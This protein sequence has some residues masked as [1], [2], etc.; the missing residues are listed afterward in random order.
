MGEWKTGTIGDLFSLT[1]GYAFKSADF[2]ESGVPVIKIKNVKAGQFSEHEFSHV[3]PRFVQTKPEKLAKTSDLLISMSGNRHDGSPETW[4]GKVALFQKSGNYLINQRVGALRPKNGVEIDILFFSFLLSSMPYQELFISIATSSGGQANLSPNQILSAP[5]KY[6][7]LPI[8]RTIG[9]LLGT[10]DDKIELNR[11]MNETL[12]AMARAIF[13]DWFVDF[14]PT[15]AKAEGRAPYLSPELW[16]LF[17]E[18]LDDDDKPQGWG[19][20]ALKDLIVLQRGFDLPKSIRIPGHYPVVAASGINGMHNEAKVPG[21]GVVTGRSGVIGKVF[22]IHDDFWP[23]NTSL[24]VKAFPNSSPPHAYFL[25]QMLDFAS[26]NSGSAVPT[27]NR[28][29]V[30]GLPMPIPPKGLVQ[31]F[32]DLVEPLLERQRQNELQNNTLAQAR[33]LLLPKLMSGEIRLRDA[34]KAV[35]AVA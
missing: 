8:Q 1:N 20:G 29:H 27:L 28:N 16:N 30:H 19:L 24:W 3:D 12:E 11:R 22:F 35:E 17:P 7:D 5:V 23:L 21:P 33:D 31:A 9:S 25:I 26:F 34:E 2:I 14:G 15:R 4:V 6:P 18:T 13:K 32:D 10:L